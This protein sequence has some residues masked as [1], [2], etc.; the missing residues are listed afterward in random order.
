MQKSWLFIRSVLGATGFILYF[1][2]L[3]LI[4]LTR[5]YILY[6]TVMVFASFKN[7]KKFTGAEWLAVAAGVLGTFLFIIE[8]AIFSLNYY[9]NSNIPAVDP[10]LLTM[11]VLFTVLSAFVKSFSVGI[12]D[13]LG[14]HYGVLMFYQSFAIAVIAGLL[15]PFDFSFTGRHFEYSIKELCYLIV[16]GLNTCCY[17][18]IISKALNIQKESKQI[19][20]LNFLP[21]FYFVI[22]DII[23]F[24]L[25]FNIIFLLAGALVLYGSGSLGYK[26]EISRIF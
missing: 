7:F 23:N 26:F 2:G 13:E 20:I 16:G 24:S 14:L 9:M 8:P 1:C 19:A 6:I 22:V 11:G 5:N 10:T 17:H 25:C 18:L 21:V 12:H 15:V 4:G 3:K